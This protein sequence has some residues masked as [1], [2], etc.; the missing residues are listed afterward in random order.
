MSD[1]GPVKVAGLSGLGAQGMSSLTSGIAEWRLRVDQERIAFE[2]H[3]EKWANRK[4]KKADTAVD[5]SQYN[6]AAA[7][8]SSLREQIK[9]SQTPTGPVHGPRSRAD[10]P[11]HGLS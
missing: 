10:R 8:L 3:R 6:Q 11:P 9:V 4:P 5:M 1:D 2:E 7:A